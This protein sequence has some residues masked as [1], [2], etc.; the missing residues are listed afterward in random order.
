MSGDTTW[1]RY[2]RRGEITAEKRARGWT[3]TTSTGEVMRAQPGDWAVVDDRGNERSIDAEVF[4]ATH[5]QIGPRRYGRSATVLA[6][7]ATEREV[8]QTLEGDA[9]ADKDDWV[10]QGPKGEQWPVPD[11]QFRES[12]EGPL[13]RWVTS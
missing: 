6:R 12:Y 2:R 13:D 5:E 4:D 8:I 10:V 1:R 7:Q 3:W 11:G 9:V